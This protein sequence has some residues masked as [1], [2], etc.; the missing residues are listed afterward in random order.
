LRTNISLD[1][2][3]EKCRFENV[4]CDFHNDHITAIDVCVRKQLIAT[5][6]KDQTIKVWNYQTKQLEIN[7]HASDEGQSI[8][9]HPS[10]FHLVVGLA[11]KVLIMNVLSTDL[12][13]V[14]SIAIKNC[15]EIRFSHGGHLF[16]VVN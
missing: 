3:D 5:T 9:F 8:A 13:S 1:G 12:A 2:T 7:Y 6:G 11:E 14:K 4:I 16:V 10:G 15:R